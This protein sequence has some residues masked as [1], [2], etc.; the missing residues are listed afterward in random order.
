MGKN[1][2]IPNIQYY[3]QLL[4]SI[5]N[6]NNRTYFTNLI[7]SIKKQNGI[8]TPNQFHTLQKLKLGVNEAELSKHYNLRKGERG[9]ILSITVSPKAFEGYD[10]GE[11]TEKVRVIVK[12]ELMLRLKAT[13]LK[14]FATNAVFIYKVMKPIVIN[15]DRQF[16]IK[17]HIKYTKQDKDGN[18]VVMDGEGYFFYVVLKGNELITLMLSK[19]PNESDSQLIEDRKSHDKKNNQYDQSVEY[20]VGTASNFDCNIDIDELHGKQKEIKPKE[21]PSEDSVPYKVRTDYRINTPFVHKEYGTGTIVGTSSGVKG[22]GDANGRVDWV[23]VDF[24]KTYV[25]SGKPTSIRRISPVFT[26]VYFGT[27]GS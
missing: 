24:K 10:V 4:N 12:Q 7:N 16:D 5:T 21:K 2:K 14:N 18:T 6:N 17:S 19:S 15:K 1:I 3:E 8:A 13:E 26:K 22:I 27:Q 25:K 23:D 20:K 11:A 9:N